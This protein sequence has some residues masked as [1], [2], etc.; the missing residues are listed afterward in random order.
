MRKNCATFEVLTEMLN[1]T[2][3]PGS[4]TTSV[5]D[6]RRVVAN[7]P[8]PGCRFGWLSRSPFESVRLSNQ[9]SATGEPLKKV[10]QPPG[11][12]WPT[13]LRWA[14]APYFCC[15][16]NDCAPVPLQSYCCN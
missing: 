1:G 13:L 16:V 7:V 11:G 12:G 2:I 6:K 4:P 15:K 10:G 3:S 8:A 14:S 5:L 9:L